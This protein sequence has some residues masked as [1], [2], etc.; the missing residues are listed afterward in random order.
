MTLKE[1]S[2]KLAGIKKET[3]SVFQIE[4]SK[5]FDKLFELNPEIAAFKWTQ[6]TPHF[7]DGDPCCF[8]VYDIYAITQKSLAEPKDEYFSIYDYQDLEDTKYIHQ[9]NGFE[10]MGDLGDFFKIAFGDGVE[11][12]YDRNKKFTVVDFDHD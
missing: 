8:G 2:D 10:S 4:L 5:Y 7:N 6:Y 11:V 9:L 1:L 3:S 12:T